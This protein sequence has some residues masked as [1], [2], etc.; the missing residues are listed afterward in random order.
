MMDGKKRFG[1]LNA[2]IAALRGGSKAAFDS[3]YNEFVGKVHNFILRLSGDIV[4]AEDITQEVFIKLWRRREELD[5]ALNIE[6]WIFVCAKNLFLNDIRHRRHED[7]FAAEIKRMTSTAE[8]STMNQVLFHLAEKALA[9][10]IREMPPQRQKIFVLSKYHGLS[11]AEIASRMSISERT[12]ENQLY[13][14]RKQM[15]SRLKDK[16]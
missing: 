8:E 16:S 13:Q 10:S 7:A 3:L 6:S 9:D 1:S 12:V 15:V 5:P 14:A 2:T 4:L 11:A